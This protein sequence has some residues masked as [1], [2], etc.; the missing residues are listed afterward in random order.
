RFS[1]PGIA[2]DVLGQAQILASTTTLASLDYSS[3][4]HARAALARLITTASTPADP[5]PT[6]RSISPLTFAAIQA[7][8][9]DP[10]IAQVTGNGPLIEAAREIIGQARREGVRLSQTALAGQLRA[11]G[12]T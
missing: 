2:A 10:G 9:A 1:E 7:L 4:E 8:L 6:F 5:D 11:R 3:A 12:F